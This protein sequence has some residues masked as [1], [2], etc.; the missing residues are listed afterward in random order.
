[1]KVKTIEG[2]TIVEALIICGGLG[3]RLSSAYPETPKCLVPING[4]PFIDILLDMLINKKISEITFCLGYLGALIENYVKSSYDFKFNFSSELQP[5]GTGGAILN[6]LQYVKGDFFIAFNGDSY[7]DIDLEEFISFHK[8]NH[9]DCSI[10]LIK[11]KNKSSDVGMVSMDLIS[12]KITGFEEKKIQNNF[13]YINAGIYII[14]KNLI[15]NYAKKS[16]SL[17]REF[18]VDSIE[19]K[20]V[21][22]FEILGP[23]YDIG[24]PERVNLFSSVYAKNIP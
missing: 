22:G 15:K 21:F 18:F 12:K 23:L 16:F 7:C 19:S 13:D 6:A 5:L 2:A 14:N 10:A 11:A 24:T 1:M 17:E 3:T 4:K 20:K 9:S 8:A